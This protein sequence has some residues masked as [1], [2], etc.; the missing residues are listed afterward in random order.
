MEHTFAMIKPDAFE[1]ADEICKII[2]GADF[3]IAEKESLTL[4]PAKAKSFY[5]EH[6]DRAFFSGLIEFITSGTIVAMVLEKEN[7]VVDWRSLLGPTNSKQAEE[8]APDSIRARYGTDVQKN[9]AHGSDSPSAA[10]REIKFFFPEFDLT[11]TH[12]T[13]QGEEAKEYLM[14]TV[15]PTLNKALTTMCRLSPR[16][17]DPLQWLSEYISTNGTAKSQKPKIFFV[18]GGP[19][20]GK[21]T[22]CDK[23]VQE[24]DYAHFSAGDLLRA[25]VNSGSEQGAMIDGMIKD[26]KIVAGEI[27]LSLLRKAIDGTDKKGVLIDGFPRKLDQ[28]GAF[29]SQVSDFEFVLF[30]DCPEKT[31]EER[32]LQRGK[33]SGRVDDNAESIRKRFKTFVETS[34]PVIEY[35]DAKSKVK[36]I[37][38]TQSPDE[39]YKV[40]RENFT[41]YS[42]SNLT[43]TVTSSNST[44]STPP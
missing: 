12:R 18:L 29:E 20:A 35:Y 40:V 36:R 34:L 16:P 39:V 5:G 44:S 43:P 8:E 10:E 1:N 9:A 37:D 31:M 13:S 41:V 28:A 15:V 6:K 30:F 33:T 7:A 42:S 32:L 22:Q 27:T 19:G 21:G 17:S 4:T 38:A 24:F 25:E 3:K 2:E 11:E 23:I 14:M 26:G